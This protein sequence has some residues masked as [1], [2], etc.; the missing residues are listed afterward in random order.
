MVMKESVETM[1]E[2]GTYTMAN[3]TLTTPKIDQ[4]DEQTSGA[5]VTVD[6]VVNKDS[7]VY[8]KTFVSANGFNINDDSVVVFTPVSPFGIIF[9]NARSSGQGANSAV[10]IF[11]AVATAFMNSIYAGSSVAF[12]TGALTGTTGTDGKL[13]ISAHSDGNIYIENRLG[14]TRSY[15][16]GVLGN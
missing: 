1:I 10:G 16:I 9:V 11:R 8:A 15:S 2:S 14:A 6:G 5:G 12:T 7:T 13:T 3:K 4:I